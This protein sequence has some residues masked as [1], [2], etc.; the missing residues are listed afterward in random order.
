MTPESLG[1]V[2]DI[3]EVTLLC[4]RTKQEIVDDLILGPHPTAFRVD[5]DGI[6]VTWVQY[7]AP[8]PPSMEQAALAIKSEL[9]PKKSG[10]LAYSDVERILRYRAKVG[11]CRKRRAQPSIY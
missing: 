10:I 11:H 3:D 7:F 9:T 5:E 8:P 1:P 6:S 4:P 2:P